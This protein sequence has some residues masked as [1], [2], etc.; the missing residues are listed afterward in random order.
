[1]TLEDLKHMYPECL[2]IDGHDDAIIGVATQCGGLNVVLYDE[3][4]IIKTLQQDMTY[5]EAVEHFDFNISGAYV[6]KLTPMF[7]TKLDKE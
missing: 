4:K 6:G 7:L 1:M 3:D 5:E 2:T